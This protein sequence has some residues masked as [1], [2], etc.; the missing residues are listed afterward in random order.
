MKS[1]ARSRA[2]IV[3]AVFYAVAYSLA[4]FWYLRIMIDPHRS[5]SLLAQITTFFLA[6]SGISYLVWP[7]LGHPFMLLS[8]LIVCICANYRGATDDAWFFGVVAIILLWSLVRN[9]HKIRVND[10]I[11]I[12]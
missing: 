6:L 5:I 4:S 12:H 2:V 9:T 1:I 10:N 3:I 7:L 8:T 11:E